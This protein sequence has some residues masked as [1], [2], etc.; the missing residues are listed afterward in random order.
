TRQL[1]S[2]L[3]LTFSV[4]RT[5]NPFEPR[6]G[7]RTQ[8]NLEHASS[9]TLSDFRYNRAAGDF[10]E[11]IPIARHSVVAGHVRFGIVS[12]LS[13]TTE[14]VGLQSGTL[15]ASSILHPRKRFYAGGSQSVRGY[16][17][18]Q[19][20]PRVLTISAA[21]LLANDASNPLCTAA[22]IVKC[23][24][25][26]AFKDRDFEPR[27]LGGNRL[28]EGSIEFRFPLFGPLTGATFVDG[29]YLAQNTSP[30]LPKSK[31][32]VTPGFGVRYR[33]PV[34][35]VRID[36]GVN[37][38]A[39]EKLPVVTEDIANGGKGLVTLDAQRLYS[40]TLQSGGINSVLA[41][42]TLHLS[43]GEAF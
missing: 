12:A 13:S 39:S 23:N 4:D 38:T 8:F 28:L 21:K 19:L 40:P 25:N 9:Y 20:G 18:G 11:F 2:P 36:V 41:R 43:I 7:Y 32:A 17:E 42:L 33:S 24:P 16:G 15:D 1:L 34:G 30:G 37:P 29:A 5:D 14:A 31:T 22:T 35:P 10:A 3:A 6:T 27:P 26:G